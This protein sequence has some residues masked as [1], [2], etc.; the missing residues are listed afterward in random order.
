MNRLCY[1]LCVH[2]LGPVKP[3]VYGVT[4]KRDVVQLIT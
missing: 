1:G 3:A 2:L 4:K